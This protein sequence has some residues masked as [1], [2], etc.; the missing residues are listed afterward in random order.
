M[1]TEAERLAGER[2]TCDPAVRP[3]GYTDQVVVDTPDGKRVGID[4]CIFPTVAALWAKGISTIESCCG[5]RGQAGYIAVTPDAID[6]MTA[7]GWK[8]D[9][10]TEAPGVFLWPKWED[11]AAWRVAE[12]MTALRR[13]AVLETIP[14]EERAYGVLWGQ[15][16]AWLFNAGILRCANVNPATFV[17]T[18]FGEAV[19]AHLLRQ[20]EDG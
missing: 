15:T 3:G 18:E 11:P 2:C 16:R 8:A 4:R 6:T 13:R 19:R 9:P 7:D 17:L 12:R 10:R 5:H 1:T 14:G 20:G